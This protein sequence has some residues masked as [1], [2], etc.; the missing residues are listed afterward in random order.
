MHRRGF[1]RK[2]LI[3]LLALG[4]ILSAG[5]SPAQAGVSVQPAHRNPLT[6]PLRTT[7]NP[8]GSCGQCHT[9][10]SG[11]VAFPKG[12]WRENDNELCYTCH[13]QENISGVYPGERIYQSSTHSIDPRVLW[14]GPFPRARLAVA[15]AGKCLNCHAPHGKRD[16]Y[17]L[18]PSLLV[19]REEGLCLA[20]HDGNPSSQDIAREIRKPYAH[21]VRQNSGR[22]RADE[23]ADPALYSNV[24]NNRHVECSDCHN[25]HALFGDPMPPLAPQASNRNAWVSRIRVINGGPGTAPQYDY[26]PALDTGMPVLE[27]EICFKCHSS[28]VQLPPGQP[29][30]AR[31]FNPNNASH[32][33]VERQGNSPGID[34]NAF[35]GGMNAFST[36]FC[37]DCHGS[38][39]GALRGPHGSQFPNLLR[40]PYEA[41][42]TNRIVDRDELCFACHNFDTYANPG[43]F[44]LAQQASRFNP[45]ASPGGHTFHI[46]QQNVP[47]FA[48]HDSHGSP[49]FGALIVTGRS[50]GLLSFSMNVGGGS[51]MPTC[52]GSRPYSINYPR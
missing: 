20:C 16:L 32:H 41:N 43:A 24:G 44:P 22:H 3:G 13:R 47:C 36:I 52:H 28:W 5:L 40:R 30:L 49:R 2:I 21:A 9:N 25:A 17:G 46:T 38:E 19:L 14:P 33:P 31:L 26:L 50:P 37:S 39:D 27:Y 1:D 42:S 15:D 11:A 12:L 45:P 8:R 6:G 51:C 23:G 34:P 48:C 35:A 10:K 4:L 7:D 29:D 18:I